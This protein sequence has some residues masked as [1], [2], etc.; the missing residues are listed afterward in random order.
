MVIGFTAAKCTWMVHQTA[1]N[2]SQYTLAFVFLE[3]SISSSEINF[4]WIRVCCLYK[5]LED[6]LKQQLYSTRHDCPWQLIIWRCL[7][8]IQ[9]PLSMTSSWI[10]PCCVMIMKNLR[11]NVMSNVAKDKPTF[12]LIKW[13]IS[14]Q[15]LMFC[16]FSRSDSFT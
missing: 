2:S 11:R 13:V 8:D 5:W 16:I 3:C 14:V 7:Q 6:H 4:E 15:M 1:S 12:K 9:S 10:I